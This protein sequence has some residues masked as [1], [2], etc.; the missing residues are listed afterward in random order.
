MGKMLLFLVIG[1]GAL[2]AVANLNMTNSEARLIDSSVEQ[3]EVLQAKNIAASGIEL[4]VSN[5]S[6]DSTWSGFT[7]LAIADGDLRVLVANTTSQY[8][9]GPDMGLTNMKEVTAIGSYGILTEYSGG[10]L[11]TLSGEIHTIRAVIQLSSAATVPPFLNYAVASEADLLLQGAFSVTDDGNPSWNA[12]IHTNADLLVQGGGYRVEGF[13]TYAGSMLKPGGGTP[14]NRFYPNQNPDGLA[15]AYQS[16][17]VSIPTFNPN[18]YLGIATD[19]YIGTQNFNGNISMGTEENPRIIYIDGDL[20]FHGTTTGYGVFIVTGTVYFHGRSTI[21]SSDPTGSNLAFYSQGG[22]DIHGNTTVYGQIFSEGPIVSH[23]S[24][25]IYGSMASKNTMSLVG[26]GQVHYRPANADLT[27]D[28][29]PSSS[30]N[31]PR[32]VSYYD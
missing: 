16:S 3:Y 15:T 6:Q 28:F 1:M 14:K 9:G 29:W 23:G 19:I 21:T 4:A 7:S 31:R 26:G 12:N 32:T 24:F 8:P 2:F 22:V 13:G 27:N 5:L 25:D 10:S 30:I 17:S 11:D 20:D 18:D